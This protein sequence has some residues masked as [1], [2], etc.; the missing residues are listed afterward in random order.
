MARA[1]GGER[2]GP[3]DSFEGEIVVIENS[4][5]WTTELDD[6]INEQEILGFDAEWKPDQ[7]KHQSNPISLIQ[8]SNHDRC[9]LIRIKPGKSLP[10]SVAYFL[11]NPE[12]TKVCAGYD[13]SDIKKM[14]QTFGYGCVNIIGLDTIATARGFR[15]PGISGIATAMGLN[16]RKDKKVCRSNWACPRLSQDQI[17]YAAE[18]AY[19]SLELYN[20]IKDLPL[21]HQCPVT[22]CWGYFEYEEG[23]APLREMPEFAQHV[24]EFHYDELQALDPVDQERRLYYLAKKI[25]CCHHCLAVGKF[26]DIHVNCPS[27]GERPCWKCLNNAGELLYHGQCGKLPIKAPNGAQVSAERKK[28]P[29]NNGQQLGNVPKK[30]KNS[31]QQAS[32]PQQIQQKRGIKRPRPIPSS[33]D[34]STPAPA[35][36]TFRGMRRIPTNW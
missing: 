28:R 7:S 8:L 14:D 30:P 1:S 29:L 27:P 36:S 22:E 4:S 2:V 12:T 23:D 24:T 33:A 21:A 13:G 18:D 20:M 26:A 6:W 9:V 32:V 35:A 17:Q 10:P 5:Q 11:Q 15:R 19:Y 25:E 31:G 34:C 16:I 3:F